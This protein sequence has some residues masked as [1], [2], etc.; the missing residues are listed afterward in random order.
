MH[1]HAGSEVW[2]DPRCVFFLFQELVNY[3]NDVNA[4]LG[5]YTTQA[6]KFESFFTCRSPP[7]N[8]IFSQVF[9]FWYSG[10]VGAHVHDH[11]TVTLDLNVRRAFRL[12]GYYETVG[13]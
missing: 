11:L 12:F 2:P 13:T 10:R 4:A 8:C 1:M 6:R 5:Q 7:P 9:D 3:L